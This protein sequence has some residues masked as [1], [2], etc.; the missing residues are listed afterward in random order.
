MSLFLSYPGAY[1]M[2]IILPLFTGVIVAVGGYETL[3]ARAESDNQLNRIEK[4]T[5][6][7]DQFSNITATFDTLKRYEG[8][9]AAAGARDEVLVAVLNQYKV[10]KD[11][12]EAREK[13]LSSK[14]LEEKFNLAEEV[15]DILNENLVPVAVPENLKKR[16]LVLSLGRNTFRVL[17]E[18]PMATPPELEFFG[19]PPGSKASVTEKSKFG[20][21]VVFSPNAIHVTNFDFVANA[22]F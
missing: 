15:L 2:T 16:S 13:F 14:N 5:E 22:I 6:K 10:M 7:L 12:V 19:L 8:T 21:T 11:A 1:C 20:F 3:K 4:Y 9:L 18:V 17:F